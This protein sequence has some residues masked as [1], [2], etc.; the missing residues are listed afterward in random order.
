MRR[1]LSSTSTVPFAEFLI[2]R[3]QVRHKI[4]DVI[5]P[6]GISLNQELVKQGWCWW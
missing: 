2:Q 4:A 3:G 5:L 1:S 6:D